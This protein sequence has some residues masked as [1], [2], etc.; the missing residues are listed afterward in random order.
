MKLVEWVDEKGWKR[1]ALVRDNDDLQAAMG[2]RDISQDPPDIESMNWLDIKLD[3]HNALVDSGLFSI[4]DVQRQ[5]NA[6]Q[7][8]VLRVFKRHLLALYKR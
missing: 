2:G 8:I 4:D 1:R 7:A 5:Q 6:L 3:L